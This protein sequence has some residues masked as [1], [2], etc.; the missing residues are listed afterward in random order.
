MRWLRTALGSTTIHMSKSK[1]EPLFKT[2]G[3]ACS[4]SKM[5]FTA[6]YDST[7]LVTLGNTISNICLPG[8]NEGTYSPA[9]LTTTTVLRV[10]QL[11]NLAVTVLSIFHMSATI[12]M[13]TSLCEA[14]GAIGM[15]HR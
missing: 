14:W 10:R 12:M 8:T 7:Q 9:E 6:T 5:T 2:N 1:S 13:P 4:T 15:R 11:S 3:H